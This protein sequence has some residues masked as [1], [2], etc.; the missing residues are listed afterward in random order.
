MTLT[1][2]DLRSFNARLDRLDIVLECLRAF[3]RCYWATDVDRA[4]KDLQ[5]AIAIAAD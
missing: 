3:D 5:A 4:K 2:A 1:L